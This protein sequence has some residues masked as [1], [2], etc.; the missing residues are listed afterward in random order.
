MERLDIIRQR[1]H[2][3]LDFEVPY[4][5][6]TYLLYFINRDSMKP[7]INDGNPFFWEKKIYANY[8]KAYDFLNNC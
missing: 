8:D 6:R 2:S 4:W 5:A 1:A 3:L 7:D